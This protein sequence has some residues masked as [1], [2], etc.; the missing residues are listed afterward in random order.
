MNK[1]DLVWDGLMI[2]GI[3]CL[4]CFEYTKW[5]WVL[6]I[7]FGVVCFINVGRAAVEGRY[8]KMLAALIVLAVLLV[9]GVFGVWENAASYF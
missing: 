7:L 2:V 8:M 6:E 1:S 5:T 3:F 4:A 9:S